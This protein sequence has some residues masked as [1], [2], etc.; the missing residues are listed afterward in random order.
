MSNRFSDVVDDTEKTTTE[1]AEDATRAALGED[2]GETKRLNVRVPA[3]LYQRFKDKVESEGRTMT[4][5]VLQWIRE[6]VTR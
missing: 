3:P 4:W 5:L 1:G 2:E 6:Y